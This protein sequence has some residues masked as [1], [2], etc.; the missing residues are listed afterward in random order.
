MFTLLAFY[1]ISGFKLNEKTNTFTSLS[2]LSGLAP[3]AG[4]SWIYPSEC[5]NGLNWCLKD[6]NLRK[7]NVVSQL[8]ST[9]DIYTRQSS[10]NVLFL[11]NTD[12]ILA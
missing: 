10:M 11:A 1:F 3:P 4:Y 8:A 7:Y 12:S 5:P 2:L 9:P 6:E